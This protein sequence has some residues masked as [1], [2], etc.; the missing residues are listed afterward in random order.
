M[1][2]IHQSSCISHQPTFTGV[3]LQNLQPSVNNQL[4]AIEPKYINIPLGQL[5]RMGRALRMGVGTG[6]TLL[7][8]HKA[9]GILI[10]TSNG[11]I[12]DSITFLNQI[13]DYNEGRLTPTHFVQSTFNAIA[14]LLGM[15]THNTGYNATHVHRGLAFENVALDVT[16]LLRENPGHIYLIGGVDEISVRNYRMEAMAGWYKKEPISNTELYASETEGALPGEGAAMFLVSNNA[17][18]A[19]AKLADLKLL[20]TADENL[21]ANQFA[22]F[23]R[24]REID[25]LLSGE[26]GDSRFKR[27]YTRCEQAV[28]ENTAI[29]RYKHFTGEFQTASALAL[30]FSCWLLQ[31][32]TLPEHCIKR[33]GS[34][35]A[36][37]RIALYNN[38][39][40][41]Q[42]SFM[43]VE[44]V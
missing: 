3:D 32:Q 34:K 42:H 5:R 22:E 7:E 17:E 25:L 30:W 43:L 6:I 24:D 20:H 38:Y 21:V 1:F 2:Y 18:S 15:I 13:V 27:Y 9:D 11:G 44:S 26:S 12:E 36:F 35:T 37:N 40:G 28:S 41:V 4:P 8:K 19:T 14:G 31:N 23:V 16:M 33:S 10:A 29:A 39:Q